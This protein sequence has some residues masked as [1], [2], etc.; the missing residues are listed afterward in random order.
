MAL[1][2]ALGVAALGCAGG[3]LGAEAFAP[4]PMAGWGKVATRTAKGGLSVVPEPARAR[5]TL[6]SVAMDVDKVIKGD[7]DTAEAVAM[8]KG[9]T[10]DW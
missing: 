1:I 8:P 3:P 10:N 6:A 5:T 9:S 4:R 7:A 2:R